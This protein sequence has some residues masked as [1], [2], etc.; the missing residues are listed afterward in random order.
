[1]SL[2]HN[3]CPFIPNHFSTI[4]LQTKVTNQITYAKTQNQIKSA[5]LPGSQCSDAMTSYGRERVWPRGY[6]ASSSRV[7]CCKWEDWIGKLFI[8]LFSEMAK[9]NDF[10]G[11]TH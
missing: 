8:L 11:H 4:P 10:C 6:L 2:L 7:F 1:M 3:P 9:F 5:W